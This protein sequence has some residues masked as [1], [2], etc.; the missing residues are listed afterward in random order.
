MTGLLGVPHLRLNS[1]RGQPKH[2]DPSRQ[3]WHPYP[4][5]MSNI[6]FISTPRPS[7][8][9]DNCISRTPPASGTRLKYFSCVSQHWKSFSGGPQVMR[10]KRNFVKDYQCMRVV[11]C[12][13]WMLNPPR[14]LKYIEERLR[15]LG[16]KPALLRYLDNVQDGEDAYG[17]LED[18]QEAVNDYMVRS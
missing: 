1:R 10:R 18:L 5:S 14:K 2:L 15:S 6:R 16:G 11:L 8:L 7:P 9:S 13:G 4:V 12:S 3:S 17:L